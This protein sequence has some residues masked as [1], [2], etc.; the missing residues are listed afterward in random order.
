MSVSDYLQ[1]V[2]L[3][4]YVGV[5]EPQGEHVVSLERLFEDS[6]GVSSALSDDA[7]TNLYTYK[8][9]KIHIK[10]ICIHHVHQVPEADQDET[11][12]EKFNIAGAYNIPLEFEGLRSTHKD[13]TEWLWRLK[14]V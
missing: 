2:G 7:I 12:K 10:S 3:S 6:Q 11:T 13:T 8:V 9:T 5:P 14:T 4:Q 1:A